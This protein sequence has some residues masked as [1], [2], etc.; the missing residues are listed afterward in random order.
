[1][2]QTQTK[3][4]VQIYTPPQ[5]RND[6]ITVQ[7]T[8][9]P[10]THRP[11]VPVGKDV[12]LIALVVLL[13]LVAMNALAPDLAYLG[14]W[15]VLIFPGLVTAYIVQRAFAQVWTSLFA[16]SL[17]TWILGS[18]YL[19]PNILSLTYKFMMALSHISGA[20]S[21]VILALLIGRLIKK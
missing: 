15:F 4:H 5:E 9:A 10:P 20:L 18:S 3:S 13:A 8:D 19:A 6:I 14:G 17:V 7:A 21:L 12:T 16:A 2:K 1:M 11:S